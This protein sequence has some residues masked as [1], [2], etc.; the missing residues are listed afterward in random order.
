MRPDQLV[1]TFLNLPIGIASFPQLLSGLRT[2]L[3]LAAVT[4]VLAV[5]LGLVVAVIR[6]V[7]VCRMNR[8]LA[9]YVDIFRAWPPLVVLVLIYF[10]LPFVNIRL[11]SFSAATLALTLVNGA[12]ISEVFRS[13]IESVDRG[14]FEAA[15]ALGLTTAQTMTFIV[16]PQALRTVLPPLTSNVIAL[17]KDTALASVIAVP[18]L[19][20]EARRALS[21][22]LNPTPLIAATLVY[23]A[24][25]VP[26][27]RLVGVLEA[28]AGRRR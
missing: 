24:V 12:F 17:L 18:E 2:T 21:I 20:A 16:I 6:T 13:G 15:R 7:R 3:L 10:A 1:D 25:L 4:L 28:W 23:L 11:D 19:L 9:A 5:P 22:A 8:L 14:Q 27:V 26:L